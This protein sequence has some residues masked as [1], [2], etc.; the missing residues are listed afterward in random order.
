[1]LTLG[2]APEALLASVH[3]VALATLGLVDLRAHRGVH[4]RIGAL[5]VV[6]FAPPEEGPLEGALVAREAA[7]SV[8]GSLGLPCFRYGPLPDGTTRSLPEV[9]RDAFGRL[10]PDA[11]PRAPHPTAGAVAVGARQPL[12]AWNAW[13]SGATLPQA[14]ALAARLRSD[15]VRALGLPVREGTQVSCNLL[16]PARMTPAM[17]L[18]RLCS[19]LPAGT[20]VE[21]CELVGLAPDA[22]LRAVPNDR[23]RELGLSEASS[24]SGRLAELRLA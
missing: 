15:H 24:V 1:M 17:V 20:R 2:G 5:D 12:L 16:D 6:P 10:S 23:W 22:V 4:P 3:D 19:L 11:G 18:E 13:L 21:R 14:R 9:R 7:L 8:L